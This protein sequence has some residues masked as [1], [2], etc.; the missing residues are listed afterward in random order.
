[1]QVLQPPT[2]PITLLLS[3]DS[4]AVSSMAQH[5]AMAAARPQGRHERSTCVHTQAT[6]H[7]QPHAL[8]Q[9]VRIIACMYER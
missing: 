1:M 5:H 7:A 3:L 8:G 2:L 9:G 4:S 6:R